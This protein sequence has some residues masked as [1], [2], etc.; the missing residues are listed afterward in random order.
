M[1]EFDTKYACAGTLGIVFIAFWNAEMINMPKSVILGTHRKVSI[2]PIMKLKNSGSKFLNSTR[3][4][5]NSKAFNSLLKLIF[6]T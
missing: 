1:D 3:D 6:Q 2:N 4:T 5:P